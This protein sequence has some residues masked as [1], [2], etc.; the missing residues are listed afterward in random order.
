MLLQGTFKK[1]IA[2]CLF[3]VMAAISLSKEFIF[4]QTEQPD[5]V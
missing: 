4:L 2:S 1:N 5:G 3:E